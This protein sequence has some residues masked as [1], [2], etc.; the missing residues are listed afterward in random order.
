M[1][2]VIVPAHNEQE[3][4]GACLE[5]I[6]VAS[7]NPRLRG[8]QVLIVVALDD[9]SDMT[10]RI[11]SGWGAVTLKITSRNVGIARAQGARHAIDAGA[12]WLAFTDADSVVAQDWLVAQ[13]DQGTDAVCGTVQVR[14]WGDYGEHMR[15][16]YAQTYNDADGHGHI[17]GANLGVAAI[18]YLKAGG[19]A[20]LACSEDV[21][22][23][24]ALRDSGATIAW[25]AA[26]RVMTSARR[27]YRAR[28]GFG[29]T[30]ARIDREFMLNHALKRTGTA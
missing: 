13:L 29:E 3:H 1:L 26:P 9:C 21:A 23:V 17:H 24:Q 6:R 5:S 11:A 20:P 14:D 30:L 10:E 22:F 7:W 12:R 8:E 27:A 16:H 2:A 4:I 19:F 18:A 15:R 25:S 28:G